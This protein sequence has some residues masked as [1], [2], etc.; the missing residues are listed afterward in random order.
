MYT[1]YFQDGLT[2]ETDTA[3]RDFSAL[4]LK[5]FIKWSIKQLSTEELRNRPF[6]IE[7]IVKRINTY[8][9]HPSIYKRLGKSVFQHKDSY[10]ILYH[11]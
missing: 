1:V 4:C 2:H 8:C 3:V 5:E 6:N 9:L 7:N 10:I 11:I